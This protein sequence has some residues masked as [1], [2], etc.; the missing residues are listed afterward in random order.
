MDN[1]NVK[2][3]LKPWRL[4]V[5]QRGHDN[6]TYLYCGYVKV[7]I[8]NAGCTIERPVHL[9]ML[10]SLPR[11]AYE[12]DL[13]LALRTEI[14]LS[15]RNPHKKFRFNIRKST[16][17]DSGVDCNLCIPHDATWVLNNV[18]GGIYLI[19]GERFYLSDT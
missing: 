4:Y 13:E 12:S 19:N 7:K 9:Y 2:F 14:I 6:L 3:E 10:C 5:V 15:L 1:R 17:R 18:Y 11:E 8:I 16:L